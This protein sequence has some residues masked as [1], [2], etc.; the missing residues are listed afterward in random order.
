M[1]VGHVWLVAL[2]PLAPADDPPRD[3]LPA[4]L[5]A[6]PPAGLERAVGEIAEPDDERAALGRRLFFDPV[7]SVDRTVACASCHRPEHGFADP[8]PLSA[9]VGGQST[10]RTR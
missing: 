4:E 10:T 1:S 7:L 2:A 5:S 8:R 9:G 6:L 3:T